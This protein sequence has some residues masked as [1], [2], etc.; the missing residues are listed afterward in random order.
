VS[1]PKSLKESVNKIVISREI[2]GRGGRGAFKPKNSLGGE[3]IY[4]GMKHSAILPS[5]NA[6]I[7]LC[8][9]AVAL[10][11]NLELEITN[12]SLHC[13]QVIRIEPMITKVKLS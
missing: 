3:W 11:A 1:K 5:S 8:L 13:L 4:S 10:M 9:Q 6:D 12:F 7:D 2:G